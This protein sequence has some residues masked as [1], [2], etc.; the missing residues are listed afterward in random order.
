MAN[1]RKSKSDLSER[2][3]DAL[4]LVVPQESS[5][6]LGLSG[7]MDSVVLLHLLHR[8]A[9]RFN[10]QLSA[11]HIHHGI[12]TNADEWAK[13]CEKLCSIYQVPITIERVDI[14]P[15]RNEHGIEAAARKLRHAAFSRQDCDFI[16][17][18]HHAD[19]QA[20]T[21]LLQ[22]LR[23]AGIKGVAAMPLLKPATTF[24][25]ATLRPL[26]DITRN[27][28]LEYAQ[29][30]ELNWVED[31]SNEDDYYPRN[32]LRKKILP[33]LEVKFPAY[34][35]TLSRSAGHFAE[36]DLLLDELA[37]QD[38]QYWVKGGPLDLVFLDTLS[39]HRAKNLLRYFLHA[40]GAPMPHSSQ[41]DD[42]LRQLRDAREDAAICIELGQWQVRRY[43]NKVYAMPALVNFDSHL[44]LSWHGETQ[45]EW[46]AS[47]GCLHF[48]KTTGQGLSLKKLQL[49]PVTFRLRSGHEKLRPRCNA[50]M[51]SLKNLL[52]EQ[53]IP[54]WLRERLPLMYCGDDLVCAVGVATAEDYQAAPGEESLL[55]TCN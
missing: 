47:K 24:A 23:G 36:A 33:K 50:A 20:E 26:L 39:L 16:A 35:D 13:F 14:T 3:A 45:L 27:S 30:N 4:C 25:H 54:P 17:L 19:D 11:L 52:Q 41:L 32:F 21:L 46:P 15:L 7:G 2:V 29:K 28:L 40:S 1:T 48:T 49:A 43:K 18:A 55:V 5:I 34:R 44:K 31:E 8:L 42:M 38:A 53:Q 22:L 9:P 12:S 51:R 6:V 10:W 37:Q